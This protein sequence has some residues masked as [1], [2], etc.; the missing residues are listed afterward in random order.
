MEKQF[1]NSLGMEFVLI[2]PGTFLM[3]SPPEEPYRD[4]TEVLHQVTITKPFYMMINEVTNRQWQAVMGKSFFGRRKPPDHPVVKVSWFDCMSFVERL[5]KIEKGSYRL[6]TE[7]EWEYSCRAGSEEAYSWGQEIDCSRAMY[8]NSRKVNDCR[9]YAKKIGVKKEG[10]APVKS[11]PPNR[12]GLYDMHGNVW[13]WCR[14]WYAPYP[15]TAVVDPQGPDAGDYR[16]RRGGSW[17]H[18]GNK[19][20]SANRAY[21]HPGSKFQNSGFRL[22][23]EVP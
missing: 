23:M 16:V 18:A 20:R 19:C 1:T 10:P 8:A 4:A 12:W 2:S 13:E 14:D 22:V 11:Y 9:E 5:N 21:A 15:E 7:A 3:G 17:F 6:P